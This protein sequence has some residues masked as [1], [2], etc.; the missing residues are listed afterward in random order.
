MIKKMI[1]LLKIIFNNLKIHIKKLKKEIK[2]LY[3]ASKRRD[4]PWYAKLVILF[5]VGYALSPIDLIPDFIPIVGLIDD[6]ILL[7]LGIAFAI[8]LVPS[9]IMNEC[10][11]QSENVFNEGKPKN[12]IAGSVI[13]FIWI[14]FF[15]YILMKLF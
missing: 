8:K 7:P 14:I 12:W 13:I 6:M 15:T 4:V 11:E 3:L 10:R 5:V 1:K 9:E 2:A